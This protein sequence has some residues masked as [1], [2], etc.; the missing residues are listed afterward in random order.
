MA[1]QVKIP[2][3]GESIATASVAQWHKADGDQVKKGETILTVETDKVST[4]LEAEVSGAL[5]ILRAGPCSTILLNRITTTSL[6]NARTTFR[7]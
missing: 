2:P 5:K 6:A 3:A 4:E 7:S 1:H